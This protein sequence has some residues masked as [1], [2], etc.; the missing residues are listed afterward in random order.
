M[1]FSLRFHTSSSV[2]YAAALATKSMV[3]IA[4]M[5]AVSQ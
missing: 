4:S 3:M 1:F 2:I 5:V